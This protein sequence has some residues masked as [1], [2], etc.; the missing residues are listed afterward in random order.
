MELGHFVETY[1]FWEVAALWA[2]ELVQAED[3][4]ARVL[5]RAVVR[6]GLRVQSVALRWQ[7]GS[8]GSFELRG[9]PYV[10]Y[11]AQ[12]GMLPVIMR[13]SALRHLQSVVDSAAVPRREE[14]EHEFITKQDMA[15]WIRANGGRLPAFWFTAQERAAA[16]RMDIAV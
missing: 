15:V 13:E 16:A 8:T 12:P 4:T 14:L 7:P 2:R 5:A 9:D 1:R 10:G 3:L 6:D 11:A